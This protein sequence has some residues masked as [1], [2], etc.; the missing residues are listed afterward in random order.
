MVDT[1]VEVEGVVSS[2]FTRENSKGKFGL[3]RIRQGTGEFKALVPGGLI[4][5][6]AQVSP[7]DTIRVRAEDG[8]RGPVVQGVD[9]VAKGST[10]S[11][12]PQSYQSGGG[13][14]SMITRYLLDTRRD[15]K[16]RDEALVLLR[17]SWED[18]TS[19]LDSLKLKAQ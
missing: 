11:A 19:F 8:G 16:T 2:Y 4:G 10:T 3:L 18:A 9:L 7:G 14:V 6:F 12:P 5:M 17:E 13:N 1:G 15:G